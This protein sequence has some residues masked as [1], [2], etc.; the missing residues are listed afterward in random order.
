MANEHRM[1]YSQKHIHDFLSGKPVA[2]DCDFFHLESRS[3]ACDTK[4]DHCSAQEM[5]RLTVN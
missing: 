4:M 5:K 1:L 3:S 2:E